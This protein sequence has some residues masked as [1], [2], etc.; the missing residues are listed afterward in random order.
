MSKVK[1]FLNGVWVEEVVQVLVNESD[2]MSCDAR[3]V[4]CKIKEKTFEAVRLARE[5]E[6]FKEVKKDGGFL[7]LTQTELDKRLGK[8]REEENLRVINIYKGSLKKTEVRVREETAREKNDLMKE[9]LLDQ[10][11]EECKDYEKGCPVCDAWNFY[12]KRFL[13]KSKVQKE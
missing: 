5:E 7:Y 11:G 13:V 6:Q 2:L 4:A 10:Y 12:K 8:T 1:D 9:F 3:E